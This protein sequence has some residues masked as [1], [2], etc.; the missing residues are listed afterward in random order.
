MWLIYSV[1]HV[2]L[3]AVVS[4]T[5][6]HLA[7]NNKLPLKSDVHTKVGSVLI[8]SATMCFVG[9]FLL[10][11]KTRDIELTMLPFVLL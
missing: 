3:L 4:Y 6:E 5:D 2:F 7:T 11:V 10:F 9:A 8:M 1:I